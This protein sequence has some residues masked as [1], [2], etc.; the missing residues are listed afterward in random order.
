MVSLEVVRLTLINSRRSN[1]LSSA[2][3]VV[4]RGR[5]GKSSRGDRSETG[6]VNTHFEFFLLLNRAKLAVSSC[7]C[8]AELAFYTMQPWECTRVVSILHLTLSAKDSISQNVKLSFTAVLFPWAVPVTDD[9]LSI[10]SVIK[11]SNVGCMVAM[12][13]H[14]SRF[15]CF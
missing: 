8:Q 1:S 14:F 13:I 4:M 9:L 15:P 6:K 2:F 5:E 10:P 7:L 12:E 3:W 11:M